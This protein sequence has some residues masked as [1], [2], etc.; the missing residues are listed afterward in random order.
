M[1]QF[2]PVAVTNTTTTNNLGEGKVCFGLCIY[3]P[4]LRGVMVEPETESC[5]IA[6][7]ALPPTRKSLTAREVSSKPGGV[8]LS[9]VASAHL[10]LAFIIYNLA[11][12]TQ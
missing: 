12:P 5:L 1:F 7:A 6:H 11:P 8:L 2:H 4:L 9:S 10:K 3:S